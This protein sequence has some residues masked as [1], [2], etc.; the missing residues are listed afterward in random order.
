MLTQ[1]NAKIRERKIST[2]VLAFRTERTRSKISL[3]IV[4][5]WDNGKGAEFG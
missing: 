3:D 4:G 5:T 2:H 1:L